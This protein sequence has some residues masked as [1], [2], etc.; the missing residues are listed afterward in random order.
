MIEKFKTLPGWQQILIVIGTFIFIGW[1][2]GPDKEE[3]RQDYIKW[4]IERAEDERA[5]QEA[6]RRFK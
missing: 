1:I 2:M 3:K 6:I 4:R 5:I